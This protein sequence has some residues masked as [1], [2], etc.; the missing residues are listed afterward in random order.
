MADK[1]APFSAFTNGIKRMFDSLAPRY[2][3]LNKI[4]SFG[5]DLYWRHELVSLV[6]REDPEL[7]LDLAAGTGSLSIALAERNAESTVVA[8][9]L[10][11]Q[12]LYQTLYKALKH[13]I[14]DRVKIAEANALDL[15]FADNH[16][17][18]VTCAFGVRNFESIPGGL[19]EMCRVLAPGGICAILELC[20]PVTKPVNDA[21]QIHT[22]KVIPFVADLFGTDAESFRYL[23]DSIS[24]APSREDME[25]LMREAGFCNTR[26]RV[27]LPG[28]CALYVGYKPRF[29]AEMQEINSRFGK[30][31]AKET[32]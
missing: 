14:S 2:D 28:V 15:P 23:H 19:R 10:S 8:A 9:D 27:F 29:E 25:F 30:I 18:A 26:Y 21:Y 20:E 32:R 24:E 11:K 6:S 17:D 4:N 16:F 31:L 5:F 1:I 7:I 3:L 22:R 12:M 13:G